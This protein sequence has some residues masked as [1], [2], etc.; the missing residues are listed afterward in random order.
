MNKKSSLLSKSI[1]V[2]KD[3][4]KNNIF[5]YISCIV[6]IIIASFIIVS[7][8]QLEHSSCKCTDLPHRILL[9][10][11]FIFIIIWT[12]LLLIL[13]SISNEACWNNF[14]NYPYIYVSSLIF[15]LINII[16]LIRLFLYIRL[17]RDNCNCGYGNK[18]KF[19]YWYLII[20]FSIWA[21]LIVLGLI[22]FIFT[23]IKLSYI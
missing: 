11:W 21:F 1:L 6:G 23:I 8:N 16:M 22:L 17:L 12:L 19:I 18:E 4:T 15:G 13:F 3:C 14:I 9:K 20:I 2:G 7:L 5:T 10:E